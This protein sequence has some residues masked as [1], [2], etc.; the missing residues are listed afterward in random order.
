M[1]RLVSILLR[2]HAASSLFLLHLFHMGFGSIQPGSAAAIKSQKWTV[3]F[4]GQSESYM[5]DLGKKRKNIIFISAK[6]DGTKKI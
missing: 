3:G 4:V 6:T 1:I 5:P 2:F